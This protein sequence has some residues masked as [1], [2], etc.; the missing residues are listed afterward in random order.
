[1]DLIAACKAGKSEEALRLLAEGADP[2]SG[3]RRGETPLHWAAINSDVKLVAALLAAG[4]DPNGSTRSKH[5]VGSGAAKATPLHFAASRSSL[6]VVDCL[7]Q[8]GA[9][10]RAVDSA[11]VSVLHSG[12]YS[13]DIRVLSKLI[14]GGADPNDGSLSLA[15]RDRDIEVVRELL[16]LGASP[17]GDGDGFSPLRMAYALNKSDVATLLLEAGARWPEGS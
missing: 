11:G 4:A 8:A 10:P 1:M 5:A 14:Q 3:N 7:L 9:D 2:N 6:E 16:R 15:V 17:N 12:V 13:P